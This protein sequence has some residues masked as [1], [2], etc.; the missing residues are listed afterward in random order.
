M[1]KLIALLLFTCLVGITCANAKDK[2]EKD[3]GG[4]SGNPCIP[5]D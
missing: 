1:K 3:T 4:N 5:N 2:C